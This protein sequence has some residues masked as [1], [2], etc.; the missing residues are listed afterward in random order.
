MRTIFERNGP[1]G[2][3]ETGRQL[4]KRRCSRDW[5]GRTHGRNFDLGW[6]EKKAANDDG[7]KIWSICSISIVSRFVPEEWNKALKIEY[8]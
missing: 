8:Q 4:V 5:V 7:G 1:Q 3:G 6:G 2:F